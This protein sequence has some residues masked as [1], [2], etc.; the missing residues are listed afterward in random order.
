MVIGIV[1]VSFIIGIAI[2][3]ATDSLFLGALGFFSPV[4]L[5][6]CFLGLLNKGEKNDKQREIQK[7]ESN[8]EKGKSIISDKFFDVLKSAPLSPTQYNIVTIR[9]TTL[10]LYLGKFKVWKNGDMINLLAFDDNELREGIG[11][12]K[13]K[14]KNQLIYSF[15]IN[16]VSLF[17]RENTE[18]IITKTSGGGSKFS[19]WTGN[20]KVGRVYTTEHMVGDKCT[21]LYI[22]NNPID[23]KIMFDYEDFSVLNRIINN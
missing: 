8:I 3:G 12:G 2:H 9:D 19:I 6:W 22:E 21:L 16:S 17:E 5:L 23:I 20:E 1:I 10:E 11:S 7:R 13:I 14:D 15:N 4:I 18:Q